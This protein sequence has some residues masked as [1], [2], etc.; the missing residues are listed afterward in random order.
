[1]V[2]VQ[3]CCA[4]QSRIISS[5]QPKGGVNELYVCYSPNPSHI[6]FGC[7]FPCIVVS[8]KIEILSTSTDNCNIH[9]PVTPCSS[10]STNNVYLTSQCTMGIFGN[11]A[12]SFTSIT[13]GIALK[14]T[15]SKKN[16]K[17]SFY[18]PKK[19]GIFL[20]APWRRGN[21]NLTL[22]F[23]VRNSPG[24]HWNHQR[25]CR[26]HFRGWGGCFL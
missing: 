9:W 13:S 10:R 1:M 14:S 22:V 16:T 23:L 4:S 2:K 8:R 6:S 12:A 11:L 25:C 21:K 17:V 18:W 20:G 26:G 24:I 7:S 3:S 19:G 5:S 15:M